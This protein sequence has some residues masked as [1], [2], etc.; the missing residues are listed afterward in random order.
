MNSIAP[1]FV[2][3]PAIKQN[4]KDVVCT[5]E[6]QANPAP[7]INWFKGDTPLQEDD[8]ISLT[9]VQ[10]KGT[11]NYLLTLRIQGVSPTDSGSYRADVKNK[12]GHM[13]A[14]INLNLQ[15]VYSSIQMMGGEGWFSWFRVK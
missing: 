8:R 1:R 4:G 7:A 15:G 13:T 14:N 11:N 12:H 2:Q 5:T 6:I 3:K 10:T 9:S